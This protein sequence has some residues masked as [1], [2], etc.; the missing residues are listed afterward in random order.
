V[1]VVMD[2]LSSH[3]GPQVRVVLDAAAP[4]CSIFGPGLQS[5]RERLRGPR[6]CCAKDVLTKGELINYFAAAAY[7]ASERIPL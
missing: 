2:N 4:S 5:D 7:D 6:R 3:E 1:I